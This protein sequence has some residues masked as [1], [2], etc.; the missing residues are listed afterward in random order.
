MPRLRKTES[1]R[2]A[3]RFGE[4]YRIGKARIGATEEQIGEAIGLCR[5]ALNRRLDDPEKYVKLG[6][7]VKFGKIFGWSDED[8]LAIIHAEKR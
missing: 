8:F 6:D 1:Q 5:P 3:E 2:R 4:R 7:L